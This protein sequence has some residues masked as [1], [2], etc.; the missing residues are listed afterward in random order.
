MENN[1]LLGSDVGSHG[2]ATLS[3]QGHAQPLLSPPLAQD[4]APQSSEWRP[5]VVTRISVDEAAG[6]EGGEPGPIF[7]DSTGLPHMPVQRNHSSASS[8]T[9][10]ESEP[11][12]EMVP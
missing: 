2:L 5:R 6:L 10:I 1:H 11:K 9:I 7:E 3:E 8:V 12:N 4:E